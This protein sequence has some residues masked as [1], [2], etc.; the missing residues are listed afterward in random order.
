MTKRHAIIRN[1][2]VEEVIIWDGKAKWSPPE[3][4]ICLSCE[5]QDAKIGDLYQNG[6]FVTPPPV[7]EPAPPKSELELLRERVA[8]LEA[9]IQ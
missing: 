6:E 2:I 1:G 8:A 7:R 5:K 9:K 3:G 4:T